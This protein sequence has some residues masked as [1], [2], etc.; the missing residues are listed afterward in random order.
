[1]LKVTANDFNAAK[2]TDFAFSTSR[3]V[4]LAGLGAATVTRQW[5]ASGAVPMF[6]ALVREGEMVEGRARRVIGR[7]VGNSVALATAAWNTAR[8]TALTTVNG[9][10]GVAAAA[11]P[12]RRTPA[13]APAKKTVRRSSTKSVRTGSTKRS[14][15]G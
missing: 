10:V 2:M 3:Q 12:K 13:K 4:W 15:R 8:D 5:A 9:L 1:M 7:Q 6:R 14:R 11:L